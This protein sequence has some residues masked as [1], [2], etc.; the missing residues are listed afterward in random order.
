MSD[1]KRSYRMTKRAELEAETRQRITESAVELHGTLG[2]ARTTISALAE[3][4]G[5]QRATVYRHFPDETALY[6][7][8]SSHWEAQNPP[9]DLSAWAAVENPD[10]RLDHALNELYGYYRRTERMMTNI[11][12]DET[13]VPILT[14]LLAGYRQYLEAVRE[15][16]MV[17]RS[18]KGPKHRQVHAALGHALAFQTWRSLA[19]DQGL[20]DAEVVHVMKLLVIGAEGS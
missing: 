17:G 12:R 4:A 6:A 10:E 19:I 11:L 16:L 8:C 5:V 3:H 9:P 2:P 1:E 15:T 14:Q 20:D 18:S 13:T 7:A